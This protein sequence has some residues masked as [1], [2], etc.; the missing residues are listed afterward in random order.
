M[1]VASR[2]QVRMEQDGRGGFTKWCRVDRIYCGTRSVDVL[3][4]RGDLKV[5][6]QESRKALSRLAGIW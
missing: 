2:L 5:S 4:D 3:D 1:Q 6:S